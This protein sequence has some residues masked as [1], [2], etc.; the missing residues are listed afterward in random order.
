MHFSNGVNR[1]FWSKKKPKQNNKT[2]LDIMFDDVLNRKEGFCILENVILTVLKTCIL[3]MELTMILLKIMKFFF[4]L[5]IYWKKLNDAFH[6][7]RW[8]IQMIWRENRIREAMGRKSRRSNQ[9]T[10]PNQLTKRKQRSEQL[11]P[12]VRKIRWYIPL[13]INKMAWLREKNFFYIGT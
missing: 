13:L 4:S 1:C 8:P 6:A 5:V 7:G 9:E 2:T 12:E 11:K 10:D 3:P